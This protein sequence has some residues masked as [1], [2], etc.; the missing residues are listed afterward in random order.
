MQKHFY[1]ADFIDD[2]T[3]D[4]EQSLLENENN[5]AAVDEFKLPLWMRIYSAVINAA[6][7]LFYILRMFYIM[8]KMA[9]DNL[10]AKFKLSDNPPPSGSEGD[11]KPS[12]DPA[13][14]P[15][16]APQQDD[17]KKST[18]DEKQDSGRVVAKKKAVKKKAA[19]KKKAVK[20]SSSNNKA[21]AKK[22]SVVKTEKKRPVKKKRR[23]IKLDDIDE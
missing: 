11:D 21:E 15:A 19:P 3:D 16:P 23:G 8:A 1:S 14:S 6:T 12:P 2:Q 17:I 20:K 22:D 4:H 5:E 18:T 10:L 9:L 7:W 13:P